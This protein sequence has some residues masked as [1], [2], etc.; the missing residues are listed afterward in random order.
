MSV[1]N[2]GVEGTFPVAAPWYL[3]IAVAAWADLGRWVVRVKPRAWP[4]GTVD[5][6]FECTALGP[7]VE[8]AESLACVDSGLE[9]GVPSSRP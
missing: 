2:V 8:G 3:G 9:F 6:P 1:G 4:R 5:D 7:E